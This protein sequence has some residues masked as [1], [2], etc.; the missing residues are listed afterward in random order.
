MVTLEGKQINSA[1]Q[2]NIFVNRNIHDM[3]IL[4]FSLLT[5][6]LFSEYKPHEPKF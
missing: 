2:Q 3:L 6:S 5:S 1:M 4:Q